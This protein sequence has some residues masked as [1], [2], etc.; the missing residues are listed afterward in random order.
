MKST[1]FSINGAAKIFSALLILLLSFGI[2]SC[3]TDDSDDDPIPEN[4]VRLEADDSL[5]AEWS[6]GYSTVS[7]TKD[8]FTDDPTYSMNDI[9]VLKIDSTSGIL[10]GK[11]TKVYD[12]ANGVTEDPKDESYLDYWGTWYPVNNKL[13]G[14]W[15]AVAY[16]NLS[17]STLSY[18]GAFKA[19]GI[20]AADSIKQAVKE[21]SIDK[22]YFATY[23]EL[24]K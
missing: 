19:D 22:G 17:A 15:Y 21:F 5:I 24:T 16:K 23:T 6:T 3:K 9:Y 1:R 11:Y 12:W 14:K 18:S 20:K 2:M 10:F 4:L 7:I 13:I 8:S